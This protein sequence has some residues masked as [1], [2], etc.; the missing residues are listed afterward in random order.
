MAVGDKY[1]ASFGINS[2]FQNM[3]STYM[4]ATVLKDKENVDVSNVT[5]EVGIFPTGITVSS[6]LMAVFV[7]D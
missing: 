4:S 6:A 1:Y 2:A 5:K 7:E 3:R